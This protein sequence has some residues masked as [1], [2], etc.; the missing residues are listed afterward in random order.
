MDLDNLDRKIDVLAE[1]MS[2]QKVHNENV[3]ETLKE[4]RVDMKEFIRKES[5]QDTD[6]AV[7]QDN[8]NGIGKKLGL[9]IG[10]HSLPKVIGIVLGIISVISGI[11]VI[12]NKLL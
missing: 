9:H 5:E 8:V 11:V 12:V 6:I 3:S 2:A 10:D 1:G 4:I 7:L